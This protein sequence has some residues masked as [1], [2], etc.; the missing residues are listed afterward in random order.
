MRRL[1]GGL[2]ILGATAAWGQVIDPSVLHIGTGAGTGCAQ[3]CGGDPNQVSTTHFDVFDNQNSK[4]LVTPLL[5]ILG[6]PNFSGAA[7]TMSG[8][9]S[10]QPYA[11]VATGGTVLTSANFGIAGSDFYGGNWNTATGFGGSMT[12]GEV[13]GKL[14]LANANNSNS[15]GNWQGADAGISVAATS[16]G[17]YVYRIN[18]GIVGNGLLD[19]TWS[20]AL[21]NGTMAVAYGCQGVSPNDLSTC[22]PPSPN[23]YNTPITEAGMVHGG[24][25]PPPPSPAPPPPGGGGGGGS[26]PE[27]GSI[28]LLGS[29]LF[30][31]GGIMRKKLARS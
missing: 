28:V 31:L 21:A 20:S 7:P 13:Y 15:F 29:T 17:L 4:N 5:V 23:S 11:G 12:S 2:L 3:G 25:P 8:V 18:V 9:T 27:P 1:I 24:A 22:G 30:A 19:I 14:N 10:Y 6:I 16:Y 26:V